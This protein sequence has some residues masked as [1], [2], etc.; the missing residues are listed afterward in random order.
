MQV[1]A[2]KN[3]VSLTAYQGDAMTLLAFDLDKTKIINF[4]GF[5]IKVTPPGKSAYYLF[6]RLCYP[7]TVTYAGQ[8]KP[9]DRITTQF[10]PIQ[11]FRWV[12]TPATDHNI[13]NYIFGNYIYEISA[14]YLVNNQ[15]QAIDANLTVSLTI[16][17]CPFKSKS[18]QVGFTRSFIASQSYVHN[19]GNSVTLRPK[20]GAAGF[21]QLIFDTAQTSGS[22]IKKVNGAVTTQNYSYDELFAW[23]GWQARQRI[24][25][26]ITEAIND[27][28]ISLDVFAFDLD[29]PII[30]SHFLQLADQGRI[31]V[32]LDN[33]STHTGNMSSGAPQF[34]DQFETAFKQH[35][36][37]KAGIVRGHFLSLAHSKVLIQKKGG[38]AIKVLTGS[39][40]FSTNGL[41]VNA[42]NVLIFDDVNVASLYEQIFEASYTN[43]SGF[44]TSPAASTSFYFNTPGQANSVNDAQVP[45]M[46]IRFSPHPLNVATDELNGLA[47]Q[48]TNAKSNVLFAIMDDKSKSPLLDA[49]LAQVKTDKVFTYGI[50]DT[51]TFV[52][53]YKPGSTEGIHVTG[54]GLNQKLPP[55]FDQEV[56]IPG[57]SIHHKFVVVDFNT[58]NGA[59]FCGSSN[60]ALGPEQQNGDNLLEIRDRDVVT[61][62]AI[63]A[64]RLVDHFQFRDKTNTASSSQT[65]LVLHTDD[66]W[67]K[68]Y[69]NDNDSYCK[70]R[71]LLA[72]PGK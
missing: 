6:N 71:T 14:R 61:C 38:Q 45:D 40:N 59:V 57:I 8:S 47:T 31:R 27:P 10:S 70:E 33:S 16:A 23:L 21:N 9:A 5:S 67:V 22:V 13:D 24:Y 48:V 42:N 49:V 68:A 4:A 44:K 2:S 30:C 64:I 56:A 66:K 11:K 20:N 17:V 34:E 32:V 19:F 60:L 51:S 39:T 58:D 69:Y 26:F 54:K 36:A 55:P 3:G 72:K 50:T 25:D 15:L 12:H 52:L 37:G 65:P 63:E 41:Y 62:F 29:E 43:M 53:L 1:T 18:L 28:S 7:E 35:A 46:T